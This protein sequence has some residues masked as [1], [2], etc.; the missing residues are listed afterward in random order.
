MLESDEAWEHGRRPVPIASGYNTIGSRSCIVVSMQLSLSH[1]GYLPNSPKTL[2]LLTEGAENLPDTVPFFL[3]QN[4]LRL[5]R[6]APPVAGFSERFPAPYDLMKGQLEPP[7]SS[8]VFYKGEL[9]RTDTRWGRLWQSDFSD[10][11]TPG[12]YQIET[13]NQTSPPFAIRE[14]LYDRIILGYLTFLKAQRC[15]C[16]IFGVH[17][18]CHL[19]DGILDDDGSTHDAT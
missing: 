8:A 19:D 5:P 4:C 10:F 9:R 7:P 15:G 17:T 2:T 16:L 1:L 11:T 3:R 18:G 13:D 6:Q 12:S 14:R